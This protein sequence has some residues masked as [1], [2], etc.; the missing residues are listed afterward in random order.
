MWGSTNHVH[1]IL[2]NVF[3]ETIFDVYHVGKSLKID[4]SKFCSY[5]EDANKDCTW[6]V[7]VPI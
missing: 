1:E 3:W 7:F 5:M 6:F 4:T 2:N